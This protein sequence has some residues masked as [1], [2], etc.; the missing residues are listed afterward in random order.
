MQTV[1]NWDA[2]YGRQKSP[3]S[4]LIN[5][6]KENEIFSRKPVRPV[7][8]KFNLPRKPASLKTL[9]GNRR[10]S[11][12]PKTPLENF[13]GILE[14]GSLAASAFNPL[15]AVVTLAMMGEKIRN[16]EGLFGGQ[17]ED[18]QY[19]QLRDPTPEEEEYFLTLEAKMKEF[20]EAEQKWVDDYASWAEEVDA[21]RGVSYG[22]RNTEITSEEQKTHDRLL[23]E[24]TTP[25]TPPPVVNQ[26]VPGAPTAT[27]LA[28]RQSLQAEQQKALERSR[29][30]TTQ[31][32]TQ[33]MQSTMSGI[34]RTSTA[35]QRQAQQ[36]SALSAQRMQAQQ[37][38][39]DAALS[40]QQTVVPATPTVAPRPTKGVPPPARG[41]VVSPQPVAPVAPLVGSGAY[42]PLVELLMYEFNMT[43]KT[44]I[45]Y[46]NK[47][48]SN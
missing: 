1:I 9:F 16:G 48:G 13:L 28:Q 30:A 40:R 33:Q 38:V 21:N 3:R 39:L 15:G 10:P 27:T 36:A 20:A 37:R 24:L 34:S 4:A 44:A 12:A 2:Y 26:T 42:S 29:L 46:I 35:Q 8:S 6:A 17:P 19:V 7:L 41:L 31:G 23:S 22:Q 45:K 43:R 32:N 47:Y 11:E 14:M 5:Q 25:R 18:M